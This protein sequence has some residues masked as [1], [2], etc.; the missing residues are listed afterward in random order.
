MV[1]C[2]LFLLFFCI[3]R[4]VIKIITKLNVYVVVKVVMVR[5]IILKTKVEFILTCLPVLQ[6]TNKFIWW[7][8]KNVKAFLE[9]KEKENVNFTV[10]RVALMK[11][12]R[13]DKSKKK[14]KNKY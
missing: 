1:K 8:E 14:R 3:L 7:R 5:L 9:S 6:V 11:N 10:G 12:M 4:F 13:D 2:T